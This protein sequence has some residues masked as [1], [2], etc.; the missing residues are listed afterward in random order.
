LNILRIGYMSSENTSRQILHD[1]EHT[2]KRRKQ[3]IVHAS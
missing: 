2:F 3:T 1:M